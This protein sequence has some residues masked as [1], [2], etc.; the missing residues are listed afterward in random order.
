MKRENETAVAIY[1]LEQ[2]NK[3]TSTTNHPVM[4]K[5]IRQLFV[6]SIPVILLLAIYY[7]IFDGQEK[8]WIWHLV[9]VLS[10]LMLL[11]HNMLGIYLISNVNMADNIKDSLA[12]YYKKIKRFAYMAISTRLLA[13]IGL[14]LFLING[15]ISKLVNWYSLAALLVLVVQ[16]YFLQKIWQNRLRIIQTSIESFSS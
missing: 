14:G 16:F 1:D 11:L 9:L 15:E 3:M 13:L 4:K 2:L 5:I 10:A 6:E 12:Q 7:D 8:G